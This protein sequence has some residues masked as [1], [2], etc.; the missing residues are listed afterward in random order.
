MLAAAPWIAL[1]G[2]IIVGLMF[3]V[4]L[5]KWRAPGSVISRRHKVTRTSLALLMELLF[6]LTWFG[7]SFTSG[8]DVAGQLVYWTVCLTISVAVFVLAL[9]EL[10]EVANQF[11]KL[12]KRAVRDF[13]DDTRRDIK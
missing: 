10:G 12:N 13:V 2:I 5:I 3:I 8:R 9:V 6:G 7:P 11:T 1:A 4:E